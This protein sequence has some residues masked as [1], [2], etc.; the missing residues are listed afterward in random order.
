MKTIAIDFDGVIHKYSKGWQDGKC[1]DIPVDAVFEAI[2]KIFDEGHSVFIFSTR[3]P[4]QI[5]RWMKE[6]T[7]ESD[8]VHNGMG[9]DPDDY[10]YPKFGFT[11]KV[12]PFWKKFWNE[13]N[14]VGITKRKL[15]AHCYIDDRAINFKGDWEQTL[16]EI[17]NFKTYQ[18]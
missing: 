1:Y 18:Q 7:Y 5:K 12:I 14:V 11:V 16:T 15:P 3:S 13:K 9:A 17:K 8:Y 2:R 10:C 4:K 6:N